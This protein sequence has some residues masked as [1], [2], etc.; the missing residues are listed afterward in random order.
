MKPITTSEQMMFSTVRLES[1]DGSS[2][3]GFFF[4][5]LFDNK[6]FPVLIT[7][8]HVVMNNPKETMKFQLHLCEIS[9]P[10]V[11][12]DESFT[13]KYQTEWIFHSKHDLCFTFVNPLFEEI[14][15]K[16][17][18]AVNGV[19]PEVVAPFSFSQRSA[20]LSLCL[21]GRLK[22]HTDYLYCFFIFT[23]VDY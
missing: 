6:A 17:G 8:K 21:S 15:K 3:T 1:L 16:T 23:S 2:G 5:Y 14:R 12:L 9:N 7:N 18:K 20:F 13:V 11:S 19:N 4:N 22:H 10:S